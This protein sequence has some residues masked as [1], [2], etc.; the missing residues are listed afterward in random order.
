MVDDLG[1]LVGLLAERD[2]LEAIV[3]ACY[4][5]DWAGLVSEYMQPNVVTIDADTTLADAAKQ[6]I[7]TSLRGFPVMD[8]NRIVGQMNRS[9]LLRAIIQLRKDCIK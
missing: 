1:N 8:N 5:D 6:F 9:D 2:C 7:E 4:H 3:K